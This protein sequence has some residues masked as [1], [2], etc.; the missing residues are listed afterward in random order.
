MPS[1]F[2]E[3]SP[4]TVATFA[5]LALRERLFVRVARVPS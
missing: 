1:V 3:P 5:P 4:F 2:I